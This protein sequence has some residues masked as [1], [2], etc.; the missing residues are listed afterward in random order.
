MDPLLIFDSE[1]K[2]KE[3][4]LDQDTLKET[5]SWRMAFLLK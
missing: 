2:A 5:L 3:L 4:M 1:L